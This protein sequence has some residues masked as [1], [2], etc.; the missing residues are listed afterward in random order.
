MTQLRAARAGKI[1]EEMKRV[2]RNEG[3]PADKLMRLVAAGK[4]VI[5][6]NKVRA[7]VKPLGVGRGLRVKINANIGTSPDR[8]ELEEELEKGRTAV[9]YGA[10]AIMDLSIGGDLDEIRR[11]ILSLQVP[12][13]TVP[14]YQAVV[15]ARK[16]EDVSA[17]NPDRIFNTIEKQAKDGVDFMTIHA[18]ITLEGVDRMQ[19]QGRLT[20][21]VSRGGSFLAHWMLRNEAENPLYENFHQILEIAGEY[22]V[23][24]SL[25]DALRPGSIRDSTD[26]AQVQELIILG[27]LVEE[28][29][30]A[31]VQCM[32]EGP[33]HVR[34]N[35]IEA[36]IQLEKKLCGG[37]PF[38]V[39]GPIVT[40][41]APGYDHITSA[42]GGA[43]A[44]MHGAD[45]LCYVTPAEHLALPTIEDVRQGVIASKIAAHAADLTRGIDVGLE[46]EMAR[47]RA[48]LN[49]AEQFR[50]C[51]DP[52]KAR[53]LRRK[54]APKAHDACTMCGEFCAMKLVRKQVK[55]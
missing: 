24:L 5:L 30:K 26:R 4:A 29:R 31:G 18:G 34:M 25:G 2:S 19:K 16:R 51:I 55:K 15:E 17:I 22:D 28:A 6:R 3:L 40:D 39:L 50:L 33:G 9:E 41:I 1:T 37:A 48:E 52:V 53:E 35:E 45:F 23:T 44:A 10:D 20:G 49:W 54:R 8:V 14:I 11:Q 42:I 36:N 21:I 38:Y 43:I 47:A 32:V 12:I 13:G 7:D 46:E 27:E